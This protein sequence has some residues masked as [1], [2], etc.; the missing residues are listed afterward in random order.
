MPSRPPEQSA[1]LGI[2]P[3]SSIDA[4]EL[5]T[6]SPGAH[7][8]GP[9]GKGREVEG[10]ETTEDD[11]ADG[12]DAEVEGLL[13]PGSKVE[14]EDSSMKQESGP[15][16]SSAGGGS[17]RQPKTWWGRTFGSMSRTQRRL[18]FRELATQVS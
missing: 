11:A 5:S 14:P 8:G 17:G 10:A 4:V 12:S 1:G 6:F 9:K 16:R 7:T 13:R 3:G 15:G 2:T 18:F